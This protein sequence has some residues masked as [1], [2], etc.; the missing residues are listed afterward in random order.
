MTDTRKVQLAAEMDA[1]G[2]R[3]GTSE[4]KDAVRDMARDVQ[5]SGQQAGKAVAGIGDSGGAAAQKIEG[6][7]RR[8]SDSIRKIPAAASDAGSG[9]QKLSAEQNRF[10]SN[11]ERQA[12]VAEKGKAG[13]AEY[14]ASI[15]GVSDAA[16]ASIARI[17]AAEQAVGAMGI[18]AAQTA[19]AMRGVP[20]QFTDIVTSLQGGQN[21]MTVLLQQGGQLKD[22][23]GGIGPA[24]RALGGYVA[25]LINPFT[26]AAGAALGLAAAWEAGEQES[27]EFRRALVLTGNFAGTTA[28]QMAAMAREVSRLS[29]GTVSDAAGV[30]TDLA[31]S[32]RVGAGDM[33][34]LADAAIRFERAG[35]P[36]A[37]ETA[38]AFAELAKSPLQASLK[39]N[40]AQNYLTRSVYEQI[41]ALE[42]QG[43]TT[44]AAKLAQNAYADAVV[45]RAPQV[46]QTLG[47]VERAWLSIKSAAKGA[48][49]G[50]KDIGR[51]DTL[52][53]LERQLQNAQVRSKGQQGGLLGVFYKSQVD[54]LQKQVTL[55]RQRE[56]QEKSLA[57]AAAAS[58]RQVQ[59][60]AAWDKEGE[61]FVSKR[62]QMEREINAAREQGKAAGAAEEEILRRVAAI[63]E[64]FADPKVQKAAN[65]EIAEQKKLV[66][67]LAGLSGTFTED[68]ERLNTLYKA[69]ALNLDQ[70][71]ERQGVLLAQQ[72]AIRKETEAANKA[73]VEAYEQE[74]Q[75]A[76]ERDDYERAYYERVTRARV[77]AGERLTIAQE[78]AQLLQREIELSG[79]SKAERERELTDL[80]AELDL[81]RE[82]ALATKGLNATDATEI[83]QQLRKANRESRNTKD[84]RDFGKVDGLGQGFDKESKSLLG[85]MSNF[86]KLLAR[87]AEYNRLRKEYAKD[88]AALGKIETDNLRGQLSLYGNLAGSAK[89]F[90]EEN[91][92]GYK[93]LQTAE[94]AFR[95]AEMAMTIKSSAAKAVEAVLNQGNGDP[96]SAFFRMAAM[97]AIVGALGFGTG[98]IGGGGAPKADPGNTGTGT[99]FGDA[100]A[101]S[102]SIKRSLDLLGDVDTRTMHYSK[103]MLDSLRNIESNI[104]GLTNLVIRTGAADAA[105]A[106]INAGT[107]MSSLGRLGVESVRA[108]VGNMTFGLSE[109]LGVGKLIS[110]LVGG[111]TSKLFNKKTEITGQG[112]FGAPQ[113]LGNILAGGFDASYY[114]DINTSKKAFGITY[115]RSSDTRL[116]A[117]D[118]ELERQFGQIFEGFDSAVRAAAGPLGASLSEVER[119]LSGFVVNIGKINLKDL[120]GEQI[121]ERLSAVF[122]AAGDNIAKQALAGLEVFQKVGEG[123]F[124]TVVRV[125]S[126]VETVAQ[127]LE[128]LGHVALQA[129]Q[130]GTAA[131]MDLVDAFGGLDEF[132]KQTADYYEAYYS[133]AERA[134]RTTKELTDALADLGINALP[135]SKAAW[136]DLV[137]AQDLTTES[138]RDTYAALIGLS[139]VF[140]DLRKAVEEAGQ[141]IQEE[142]DRLRGTSSSNDAASLQARFATSTAAARAGDTDA[143]KSLPEISRA[144]EEA[145]AA[146][147]GSALDLARMRAWLANSLEQ[148]L[149]IAVPGFADGGTHAGGWAVVG[150]RGPELVNLTPSQ[151][152]SNADSRALLDNSRLEALVESL[153]QKMDQMLPAL[154]AA[155]MSTHRTSK[156]LER[157]MPEGDAIVTRAAE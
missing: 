135:A 34:R 110:G 74:L 147:A 155:A 9:L 31:T 69:G 33:Q 26:L 60:R 56:Q 120:S 109:L 21:P 20:A 53:E 118:A 97:A 114:A 124:E 14:R 65:R 81:R 23:F 90:F 50:L 101:Q 87:Q 113:T 59:A 148:T 96:Y 51:P 7:T 8:I 18:S 39:L 41:K 91:S 80:R 117:A 36:A 66:L 16:S 115:S 143:L 94:T 47:L 99:V 149:H 111:I 129:G 125:A 55:A 134:A 13:W 122:G 43:R 54:D 29:G 153:N 32:A 25:G 83:E 75:T 102:E 108:F 146:T 121:Q 24:A 71:V 68:W 95:L 116:T 78:E 70:L 156:L 38:K 77:A 137:E 141:T 52:P 92:R 85:F 152:Y 89:G 144:L 106:G 133:E 17:K 88:P 49:D 100:T 93:A 79:V 157:V 6:T 12:L 15:L 46:A 84:L 58:A 103:G 105:A 119:R 64:K 57:E 63:R 67:E 22:M 123:Y 86:D 30:L 150:E 130:S 72:P 28:V 45:S 3:R 73:R 61:R 132:T 1:T 145:S 5:A 40:E 112:I 128:R 127:T 126:S 139:D 140:G 131:A 151:I 4:V 104:G 11:L 62:V 19:A 154:N 107:Q 44:D 48:L 142:I 2:V 42:E 27:A 35:G 10:L 98:A 82:I 37:A 138:G 76:K 136:R